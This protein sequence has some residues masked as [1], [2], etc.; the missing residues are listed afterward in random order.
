[1]YFWD[2][3]D[4]MKKEQ[5]SMQYF[6]SVFLIMMSKVMKC[7]RAVSNVIIY[8]L[9]WGNLLIVPHLTLTYRDMLHEN[10]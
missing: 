10:L 3:Q 7:Y 6:I 1:M 4:M 5:K 8:N 9:W 2:V